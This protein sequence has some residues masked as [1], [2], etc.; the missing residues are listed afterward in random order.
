MLRQLEQAHQRLPQTFQLLRA[1]DLGPGLL[2]LL[3]D[4]DAV[5]AGLV[6]RDLITIDDRVSLTPAGQAAYA[7]VRDRVAQAAATFF[8]RF[9][10]ARVEDA[11]SLLQEIAE[12]DVHE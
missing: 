9:D 7:R 12:L 5:L 4:G 10:P 8:Q 2:D 11:R 3:P 1:D 6:T